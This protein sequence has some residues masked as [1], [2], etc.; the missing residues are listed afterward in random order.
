MLYMGY[1]GFSVAFAF[2]SPPCSAASWSGLGALGAALDNVAWAFLTPGIALG[3]WWAYDELGWGGWWFWDPV[4]NACFMPWLV[5]TALIHALA[6]TEKRGGFRAGRSCCRS[7]RSRCPCSAPSWCARACSPRCM[8]SPP[9]RGAASSSWCFLTIVIGGSLLLYALR[10]PQ[11]AGGKP[12]RG[13]ARNAAAD[14]QLISGGRGHGA[15]GH[16]VSAD[17]DALNLGKISV[18]PPYF[19]FLFPLLMLPIVV[20]LPFG[21]FCAGARGDTLAAQ[22]ASMLRGTA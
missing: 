20:L 10:A 7:S 22:G 16:A 21:P 5:G 9:I 11:V 12:S 6:V 18:G 1:V 2:S 13:L 15:A 4:E 17:R 19:G 8:R 3:S 14:Q